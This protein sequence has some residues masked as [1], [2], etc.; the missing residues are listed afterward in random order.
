[1]RFVGGIAGNEAA[2]RALEAALHG[3][4]ALAGPGW[5]Q[6]ITDGRP[7]GPTDPKHGSD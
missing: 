4:R 1:M 7:D 5:H 2:E 3:A 6:R